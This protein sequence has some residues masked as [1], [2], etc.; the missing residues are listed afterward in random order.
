MFQKKNLK[1]GA[2]KV[3]IP[4]SKCEQLLICSFK[5]NLIRKWLHFGSTKPV[6]RCFD[7]VFQNIITVLSISQPERMSS[8]MLTVL[9][10]CKIQGNH[11]STSQ[12]QVWS[13]FLRLTIGSPGP[14][15]LHRQIIEI[16]CHSQHQAWLNSGSTYREIW[17][18]LEVNIRNWR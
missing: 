1:L 5:D 10:N 13:L 12:Q 14:Q 8:C 3:R 9:Y 15:G 11:S 7:K 17:A 4:Y 6:A 2:L 16:K 18:K